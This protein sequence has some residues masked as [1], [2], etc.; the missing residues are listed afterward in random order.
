MHFEA[1]Q[2]VFWSLLCYKELKLTAKSFTGCRFAAFWS[3]CKILALKVWACGESKILRFGFKSDTAILTFTYSLS[4]LLSFS[5][6]L[7]YFFS[8]ARH[9]LGFI[10]VGKVF[11]KVFRI[12]GLDERKGRWVVEQDFHGNFQVNGTW[13]FAFFSGVLVWILLIP[14]WFERSLHSAQVSGQSYPWQSKLMTSQ[15]VERT[16]IR[17]GGHG[18]LRGK[19]VKAS[20]HNDLTAYT[21]SSPRY[22]VILLLITLSHSLKN[23]NSRN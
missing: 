8:F 23:D 1:S 22:S 5:L 15:A 16:W 18:Q 20:G 7:P 3:R 21:A 11:R 9:L 4:L 10:L 17:T 2:A 6:F 13:F 19:W 14:V 12:F